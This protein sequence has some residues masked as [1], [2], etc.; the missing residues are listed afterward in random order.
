MHRSPWRALAVGLSLATAGVAAQ[1]TARAPDPTDARA[2]VP[3]A[4]YVS[5]LSTY[6]RA[7]EVAPL[8]WREANDRVGR[9][10]GWRAYAR[11]AA[12]PDAPAS[13]A[14]AAPAHRHR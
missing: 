2:E 5:P 3:K 11:E 1:T 14:S 6:R 7:D 12:A 13:A 8:P 9:I 4:T 10:G